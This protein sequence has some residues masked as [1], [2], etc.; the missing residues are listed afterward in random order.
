MWAK[1]RPTVGWALLLAGVVAAVAVVRLSDADHVVTVATAY[2]L[3]A[4]ALGKD[5]VQADK[6]KEN[7]R[8]D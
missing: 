6:E 2:V 8:A 4:L 7:D 3:A 1:F 5:I